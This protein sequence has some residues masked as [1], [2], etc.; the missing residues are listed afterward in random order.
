MPTVTTSKVEC[1]LERRR[2]P[3]T[4]LIGAGEG[5]LGVR[6]PLRESGRVDVWPERFGQRPEAHRETLLRRP[7]HVDQPP[8]EKQPYYYHSINVLSFNRNIST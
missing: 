6:R 3:L 7:R 5:D 2:A 8:E 1:I 4:H